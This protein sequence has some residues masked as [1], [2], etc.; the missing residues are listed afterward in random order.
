MY[1]ADGGTSAAAPVVSGV[2]AAIRS[3]RPYD[4]ADSTTS[5]AAIRHLVASTAEDLGPTG[6]DFLHG[7]GVINGC[8]LVDR[9]CRPVIDICSPAIRG[10]AVT[11]TFAGA[12]RNYVTASGYAVPSEPA[13]LR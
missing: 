5:P 7:H 3:K 8:A 1:A 13:P 9:L 2:V 11:L 4:S 12:F 6:Y 10:C